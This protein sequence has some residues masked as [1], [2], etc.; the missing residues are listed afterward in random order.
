MAELADAH[1]SGPCSRKGVEVQVLLS[2]PLAMD[3]GSACRRRFLIRRNPGKIAE[4]GCCPVNR[5][6]V[7]AGGKAV[8]TPNN[9]QRFCAL[10]A[11]RAATHTTVRAVQVRARAT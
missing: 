6:G 3:L 4:E 2:A 9:G 1:G 7:V 5:R 8:G 11:P 10:C